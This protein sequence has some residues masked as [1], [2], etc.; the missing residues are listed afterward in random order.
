MEILLKAN[1]DEMGFNKIAK[2]MMCLP[3]LDQNFLVMIAELYKK[4]N[5]NQEFRE[6]EKVYWYISN[7]L[8]DNDLK[9]A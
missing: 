8:D 9:I 4:V 5:K 7:K 3:G 2:F 6:L 1:I